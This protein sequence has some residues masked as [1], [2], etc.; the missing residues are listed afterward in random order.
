MS[1][2]KEI[3]PEQ[4]LKNTF[5]MIN[6]DWMLVT[7]EK[8]GV[9]NTMTASWGG[10]GIM[11]NKPV[12]F[13]AIRPERFTKE[14]VDDS[15]HFSLTFFPE[16]YRKELTYLGTVSGRDEKKIEKSGLTLAYEKG[17]PYFEDATTILICKKLFM[18]PYTKEAF[19]DAELFDNNYSNGGLHS[20]YIAEIEKVLE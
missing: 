19:L 20:L 10:L 14:F 12:A 13:V 11:W 2:Y 7:A 15:T 18:Q 1:A 4:I 17:I 6:H 5:Q 8:D 3:L 16:K 9:A